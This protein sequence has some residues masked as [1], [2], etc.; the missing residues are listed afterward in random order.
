MAPNAASED[1]AAA[2]RRRDALARERA[3]RPGATARARAPRLQRAE[4]RRVDPA[5]EHPRGRLRALLQEVALERGDDRALLLGRE[6][7]GSSKSARRPSHSGMFPCLRAG[8]L[9][10]LRR[11]HAERLDQPRPR[12]GRLDHVVDEPALRR[13]VRG[14]ELPL[15]LVDQL[16]A[17][18]P[19]G[20]PPSRSPC[21]TRRSPR[22]PRP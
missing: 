10:A 5:L 4:P 12:L 17:L 1:V 2:V 6:P 15:V 11:E 14:R 20:P 9:L 16:G 19:P 3:R 22:P 18:A 7:S 21:G 8:T 13:D